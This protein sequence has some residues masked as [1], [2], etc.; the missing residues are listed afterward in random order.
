MVETEVN[1]NTG[2][3]NNLTKEEEEE[4]EWLKQRNIHKSLADTAYLSGDFKNAIQEYTNAISFDPEYHVLYSN[5]SASYLSNGEKSK[6]L[7]DAKKCVELKPE[8]VKGHSRLASSMLSLGRWNEARNVYKHILN[9]LDENNVAAKKGFEDCRARELK[10]KEAE[11]AM[12]TRV[13]DE[14]R[15]KAE[16]EKEEEKHKQQE[17]QQVAASHDNN[18]GNK[19]QEDDDDAEDDLLNDFFDEVEEVETKKSPP[20]TADASGAASHNA[21]DNN[22][23]EKRIKIHLSD[24]GDT[25]TQISRI[26][27]SS[28]EWYNLN[29]FRVLDISHEASIDL[30]SS[31]YKALSLLLHPDKVRRNQENDNDT[32]EKAATAFEYIRKAMNSLKDEVKARHIVSLIEQG[33]KQGKADYDAACEQNSTDGRDVEKF[34]ETAT[35]KIFAE[36]ERKR[37]DVE[38]R[39]RKF[40]E[41]ERQQEDAEVDNLKKERDF[42]K[43]WKE[44]GRVSKRIN[45]WRDFQKKR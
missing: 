12:V 10:T 38:R 33:R 2:A 6:A 31:R 3:N 7:T 18:K 39:K 1:E 34:H 41:R 26:L 40:E 32:I 9:N 30:I 15:R 35:M 13:Q 14:T 24:L 29:P 23:G 22:D 4:E 27:C 19:E 43:N 17:V 42:N 25:N 11:M 36:I 20:Q 37:R 21:P 5:R 16:E 28:H 8:F 45:N 44:E